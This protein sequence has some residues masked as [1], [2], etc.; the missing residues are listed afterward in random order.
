M[1]L[2]PELLISIFKSLHI[3]N[4]SSLNL[5]CKQFGEICKLCMKSWFHMVRTDEIAYFKRNLHDLSIVSKFVKILCIDSNIKIDD[6]FISQFSNIDLLSVTK[7]AITNHSFHN[8]TK[9][10]RF[11]LTLN[12][13]ITNNG[14]EL[15]ARDESLKI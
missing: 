15:P 13:Y 3:N 2:L 9:L 10:T 12:D 7:Q 4:I 6:N 14:I 5:V 11:N 1:N 8:L